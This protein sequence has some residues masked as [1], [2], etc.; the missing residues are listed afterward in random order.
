MSLGVDVHIATLA[1]RHPEHVS[2][3]LP[4]M[5]VEEI[6]HHLECP[7]IAFLSGNKERVGSFRLF[8]WWFCSVAR[9]LQTATLPRSYQAPGPARGKPLSLW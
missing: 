2:K 9:E 5:A 7:K 6:G 4:T 8:S 1:Q 3:I